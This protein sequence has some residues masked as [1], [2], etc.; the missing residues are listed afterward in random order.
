MT[1]EQKVKE[2][3]KRCIHAYGFTG[4]QVRHLMENMKKQIEVASGK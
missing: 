1:K 3:R 2:I 4:E